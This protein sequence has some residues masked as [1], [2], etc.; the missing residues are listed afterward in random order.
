MIEFMIDLDLAQNVLKNLILRFQKSS[1]KKKSILLRIPFFI[2]V[3]HVNW[4][5]IYR[6]I[7]MLQ[8]NKRWH[9]TAENSFVQQRN[10]ILFQ[11]KNLQ[12]E[13]SKRRK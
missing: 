2:L 12:A 7:K 10:Y 11:E 1:K 4:I 13:R 3:K 6:E 5:E 8:T 9:E